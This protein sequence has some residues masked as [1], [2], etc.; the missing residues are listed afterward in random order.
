MSEIWLTLGNDFEP[1]GRRSYALQKSAAFNRMAKESEN[2]FVG[3]GG[4]WPAEGETLFDLI[5]RQREQRRRSD[6]FLSS[7]ITVIQTNHTYRPFD[8]PSL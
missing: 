3:A 1:G 4:T 6:S 7:G 8:D 2:L 5:Q